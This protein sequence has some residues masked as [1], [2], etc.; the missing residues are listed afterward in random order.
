M[1]EQKSMKRPHVAVWK[2]VMVL[3]GLM[4]LMP[5]WIAYGCLGTLL[6]LPSTTITRTGLQLLLTLS[7]WFMLPVFFIEGGVNFWMTL[8]LAGS[9]VA[10]LLVQWKLDQLVL[11]HL[12]Q[13]PEERHINFT[14]CASLV[15]LAAC[16][17]F[18]WRAFLTNFAVSTQNFEE[19]SKHYDVWEY[20]NGVMVEAL[21]QWRTELQIQKFYLGGHSMGAMFATSYTVKYHD[22]VQHLALI[23]PAGVG[24][25]PAPK[26]LPLGLRIFRTVWNLRLTPMSVARFAGPLGPRFLRFITSVRVSV[27]PETSCIRHGQIPQ[28]DLAAYWYN[29][30]ALEKSGE[31]AM[32]SHLLP[33]AYAKRPLC[34]MLT[35]EN[36]HIPITFLYGGGPDWMSSSHGEKVAKTFEG[37]QS[38]EV[39]LVPGA[40]HQL[41]MDNAPAFNKMLL[42]ALARSNLEKLSKHFNVYAVE[43]IGV[44]RSERPDFNFKDYDSADDFIVGSFEKWQQEME[45]EKFDLC[46]HSMGHLVLASPAGVPHPPPPPDP[47]TEEGKTANRSWLRRMV[48]S[49]W[50][51]DITPMS[52]AR[53]VGPYG[54]K[55]VQNVVHRRTS[56]MSEG[57][58]MRDGRVDLN[59]LA[60]YMYHNWALKPSGERAMTTHLAPGAHA[61]R[62]LVDVLVPEKVKMPLTFIYGEYDW[63]DYRN[64]LSIV[65][66]FK[67][68]G[69]S[70]DL[71]RVPNG[72]HQM[73]MENPDDFSRILIGSLTK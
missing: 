55:L 32:H 29:N 15:F 68:R 2:V 39:I 73:F 26:S 56:F 58:A 49:A 69:H 34:E 21:E 31:I 60:E 23:S 9:I 59:E 25:P 36:I 43:W 10:L 47:T 1:A 8:Q 22:R 72:G 33:G 51:N 71:Y 6:T 5:V 67:E 42:A 48:Y 27:M 3:V 62:P 52:L 38:V 66:R 37:K 64:G 19:L 54:P 61:V 63:M 53:F 35:P 30:W 4:L 40:G 70:A 45:L 13:K 50:E 65:E 24:Y 57:S 14:K 12:N 18:S 41:F 7:V 16:A 11:F 44:G 28:K 20:V 46:G 17:V